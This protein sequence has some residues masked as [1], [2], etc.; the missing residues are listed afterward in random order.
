MEPDVRAI[1]LRMRAIRKE[2]GYK[3]KDFSRELNISP[4]GLSD[5]ESGNGKPRHDVIFNLAHK[6][7]VNVRYL[8]HGNGE[9][10]VNDS[11]EKSIVPETYGPNTE[12]LREFLKYFKESTLVRYEMM[13]YFRTYILE[14]E[15]LIEKDIRKSRDQP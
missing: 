8:L 12:F 10:F 1:G 13:S 7:D 11:I 2:L 6:F 5:I 4:A 9:M 3:Q 14:K 15:N